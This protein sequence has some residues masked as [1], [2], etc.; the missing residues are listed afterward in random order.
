[1][2][3]QRLLVLVDLVETTVD[4]EQSFTLLDCCFTIKEFTVNMVDFEVFDLSLRQDCILQQ[5]GAV[6]FVRCLLELS[7][8]DLIRVNESNLLTM[9]VFVADLGTELHLLVNR[10]LTLDLITSFKSSLESFLVLQTRLF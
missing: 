1:M 10:N 8:C 2:H 3:L 4:A 6:A 5:L 7:N 9:L